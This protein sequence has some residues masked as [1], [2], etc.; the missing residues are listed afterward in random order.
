MNKLLN[1]L[2]FPKSLYGRITSKKSSLYAGI[3]FVGF[4]DVIFLLILNYSSLFTNKMLGD[5]IFNIIL[6][7]IIMIAFGIID[8]CCF[9][10]PMFDLFKHFKKSD[11]VK[12]DRELLIKLMKVYVAVH[13]IIFPVEL[14]I[15]LILYNFPN[16][17]SVFLFYLLS[18]VYSLIPIWF[19]SAITRGANVLYNFV[20]P[21]K[22][23]AFLVILLWNYLLGYAFSYMTNNWILEILRL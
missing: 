14:I 11:A 4:V 9:S 1:I 15:F 6:S 3:L 16:G 2:L 7:V 18:I 10:I 12:A 21:F 22:W 8:V 5:L 13:L 17:N 20:P 23:I 19:S